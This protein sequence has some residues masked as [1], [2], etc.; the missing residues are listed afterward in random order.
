MTLHPFL[1][2]MVDKGA[3]L[4]PL[5]SFTPG[6][7]RAT[8]LSRYARVPSQ[9]VRAVADRIIEGPRG[10]LRMRIYH[11][12]RDGTRPA[13]VFFHGS[14]F[15]ICSIETHDGMCRALCRESGAIVVSVDYALAPEHPFPAGPDDS[16]AATTW[17]FENAAHIGADPD[18]VALAGDSAGAAMALVTALR[19]RDCGG[20]RPRALLLAYPVGGY[21]DPEPPSWAERG[22]GCGLTA[23]AMRWFW[24]HYLPDPADRRHPHASPLAATNWRDLPAAY[25]MTAEY[26]I[27]RDEGEAIA[28]KLANGGSDVTVIR[29]ADMN[30]GFLSW[31]GLLDRAD[32][33]MTTASRWLEARL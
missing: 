33:A 20:A 25:V 9:P 26:D 12:E 23:N 30:H 4:P 7:L 19:L 31:V 28:A 3:A 10:A 8:D 6:E 14:G 13:I 27:L 22:H 2:H 5:E 16:L 32:E 17:V 1:Q 24:D 15:V 29:Y 18:R 11:P 21:P